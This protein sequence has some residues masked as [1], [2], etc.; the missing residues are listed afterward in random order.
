VD[1]W[2]CELD[3]QNNWAGSELIVA[4]DRVRNGLGLDIAQMAC[5]VFVLKQRALKQLVV[6][7]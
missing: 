4:A 1:D 7:A 6:R 3:V 5:I 2:T